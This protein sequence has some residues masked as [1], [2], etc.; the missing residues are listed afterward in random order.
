MLQSMMMIDD[1]NDDTNDYVDDLQVRH[2]VSA[3]HALHL[4]PE[5]HVPV[6]A[7]NDH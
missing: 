5:L 3:D 2:D 1:H 7:L 4:L 6:P